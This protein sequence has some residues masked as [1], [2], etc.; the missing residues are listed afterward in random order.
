M[1]ALLM[2]QSIRC[3]S[4]CGFGQNSRGLVSGS[5]REARMVAKPHSGFPLPQRAVRSSH[6]ASHA[7]GR[8]RGGAGDVR[9]QHSAG[10]DGR[11]RCARGRQRRRCHSGGWPSFKFVMKSYIGAVSSMMLAR[12]EE[13]ERLVGQ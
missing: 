7:T 3:C 2:L 11:C 5:A 1:C 12:L 13:A 4:R 8:R 6:A 10:A 9:W